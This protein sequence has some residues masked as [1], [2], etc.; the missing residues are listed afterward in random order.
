MSDTKREEILYR[1]YKDICLDL[2]LDMDS[3][4]SIEDMEEELLHYYSGA[5]FDFNN[6]DELIDSIK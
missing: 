5:G 1:L 4:V 6:I 3:E 2:D